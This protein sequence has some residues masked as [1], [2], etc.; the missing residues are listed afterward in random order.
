MGNKSQ[1]QPILFE[2]DV[3]VGT[4]GYVSLIFAIL[5]FS[6]LFQKAPGAWSAFDFTNLCGNFGSLGELA[7]GAGELASNFR[8]IG[9]VG[10]KDGFLFALTLFPGVI[11][12]LG[13]VKVVEYYG[14]LRA[15]QRLLTPLLRPLM[16]IPGITGLTLIASLQST[17]AGGSMTK[18]LREN[19]LITE[20]EKTIFCAFQ[21]SAGA[22]ITNYFS[23]GAALFP[24]ME[25]TLLIIPLIVMFVCK[26]L[27]ANLMRIYLN[28]VAM[29][30]E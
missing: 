22:T 7:D 20:K 4:A 3:K 18:A 19:N 23:S 28:K 9:G 16:G 10:A 15:A 14:G 1:E 13:V 29:E 25:G 6:G 24:M 5:F 12:A 26:V 21:F 30:D 27:G 17:D 11:F 8:G 2:D